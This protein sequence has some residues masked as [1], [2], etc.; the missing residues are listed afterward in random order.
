MVLTMVAFNS[1]KYV[2]QVLNVPR[3]MIA[4]EYVRIPTEH[5]W[6]AVPR[7]IRK[8]ATIDELGCNV[9]LGVCIQDK[10]LKEDARDRKNSQGGR[11]NWVAVNLQSGKG[12]MYKQSLSEG[13]GR[14][15]TFDI[16]PEATQAR[17]DKAKAAA[18]YRAELKELSAGSLCCVRGKRMTQPPD[19]PHIYYCDGYNEWF[20]PYHVIDIKEA[21]ARHAAAPSSMYLWQDEEGV[22]NLRDTSQGL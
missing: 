9:L 5:N 20:V 4:M 13:S 17:R 19:G 22:W 1:S 21:R 2:K 11:W 14:L 12:C 10:R 3:G 18:K 6:D 15:V 16:S 8:H 7:R